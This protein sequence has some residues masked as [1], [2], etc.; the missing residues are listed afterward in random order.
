MLSEIARAL[1]V[2]VADHEEAFLQAQPMN[3]LIEP[4]DVASA[5]LWLASDESV[6][7]TGSV[8]VVDGGFTAH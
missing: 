8:V 7:V 3:A 2:P 6:H 4:D 1:D 5:V